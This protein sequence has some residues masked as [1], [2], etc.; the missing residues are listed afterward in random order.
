MVWGL[1]T[2]KHYSS[3]P[4][5]FLFMEVISIVTMLETKTGKIWKWLPYSFKNN[6]NKTIT[7]NIN[8]IFQVKNNLISKSNLVGRMALV[9]FF[10]SNLFNLWLIKGR[11]ILISASFICCDMLF[12][13]K[14]MKKN[15][16]SYRYVVAKGR[17]ILT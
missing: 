4:K 14:F 11:W 5:E 2:L 1:Y 17:N 9:F 6:S 13:L 15:L 16:V 3:N 7:C 8:E 10:F 12:W